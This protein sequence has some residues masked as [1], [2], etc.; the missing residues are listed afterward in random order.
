MFFFLSE[1]NTYR[2]A[3]ILARFDM[4]TRDIV[5]KTLD[6]LFQTFGGLSKELYATLY[7]YWD[8]S[9]Q[10]CNQLYD[11]VQEIDGLVI[12]FYIIFLVCVLFFSPRY[13][14]IC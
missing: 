10:D 5:I 1:G 9:P 12:F 11:E 4:E 8:L 2:S 14:K 13:H 3:S 6:N 7:L